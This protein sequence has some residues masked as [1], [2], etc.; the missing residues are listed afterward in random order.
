MLSALKLPKLVAKSWTKMSEFQPN[1]QQK[2]AHSFNFLPE[3]HLMQGIHFKN[4]VCFEFKKDES[5]VQ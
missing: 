5:F 2:V 1:L 3:C 4:S